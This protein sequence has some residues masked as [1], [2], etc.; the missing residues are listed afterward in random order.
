MSNN[1]ENYCEKYFVETHYRNKEDRYVVKLS[2]KK[3]VNLGSSKEI[4]VTFLN[5][6]WHRLDLTM[7]MLYTDFMD[8]F[9]HLRHMKDILSTKLVIT[10]HTTPQRIST[11]KN[12]HKVTCGV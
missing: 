7:K 3:G 6:L 1:E 9:K 11:V 8:E 12:Y 10:Y 5:T 4:A 2:F